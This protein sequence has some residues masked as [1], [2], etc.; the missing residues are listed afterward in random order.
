MT[1]ALS[2]RTRGRLAGAA[3]L[4]IFITGLIYMH[5]IPDTGVLTTDWGGV[6]DHIVANQSAFWLGFPFFL[7]SIVWRLVFA[8]LFYGL[9]RDVPV[10]LNRLGVFVYLVGATMQVVMAIC[11]MAPVV[12]VDGAEY[13]AAFTPGG[14]YSVLIGCIMW[15]SS[16]VPR[17]VG[18]CLVVS[19]LGWLTFC[20]PPI[21]ALLLPYN[22]SVGLAGEATIMLW[23]LIMGVSAPNTS[24]WIKAE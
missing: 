15:R 13:R 3:H 5:F 1:T 20:V 19:G 6:V 10:A 14:I 16:L 8:Q 12:L 7:L 2:L 23:L 9:F 24:S 18:V 4:A 22:L 21:A 17:A 11:L